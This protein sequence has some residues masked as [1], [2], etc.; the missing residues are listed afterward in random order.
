M[1]KHSKCGQQGRG[2]L[3]AQRRLACRCQIVEDIPVLLLKCGDDGHDR[4]QNREPSGLRVQ[5]LPLCQSTPGRMAL[6]AALLVG[7]APACRT[8]KTVTPVVT[9]VD[10]QARFCPSRHPRFEGP[11]VGLRLWWSAL[12]NVWCEEGLAVH[13]PAL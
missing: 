9:T 3:H 6:S 13:E 2:S 12:A 1:V 7:S 4:F 11:D 8:A 5:K 10:S